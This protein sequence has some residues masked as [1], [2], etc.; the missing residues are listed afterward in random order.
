MFERIG[1][2]SETLGQP[3]RGRNR[4]EAGRNSYDADKASNA[5]SSVAGG[6]ENGRETRR[7]TRPSPRDPSPQSL[8]FEKNGQ[9][10]L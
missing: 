10:V 5:P 4:N 8:P 1:R 6:R 9:S 7:E 3:L 2:T